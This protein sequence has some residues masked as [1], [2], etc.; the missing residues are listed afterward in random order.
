MISIKNL[1][2]KYILVAKTSL[3][4]STIASSLTGVIL[5]EIVVPQ[6]ARAETL[7]SHMLTLDSSTTIQNEKTARVEEP[8]FKVA[9][10]IKMV[11]TAYSSTLNQTDSTPFITASG[12]NVADGI[13]ANNML[14]FGS[15]VRIP[16]L[17]GDKIFTVE[18][19]M[20]QR[21]GKYHVD[22]WFPEYLQAKKFGAKITYIEVLEN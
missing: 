3:I 10:T 5:L 4:S 12:K 20:H 17:Y 21:M 8:S 18:D 22:I 16:E 13:I 14:P 15:K 19:R 7:L 11:I 9:K 6:I 2:K 1:T